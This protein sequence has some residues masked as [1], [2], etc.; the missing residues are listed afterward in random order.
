MIVNKDSFFTPNIPNR[1]EVSAE[2]KAQDG[3]NETSKSRICKQ[4][5]NSGEIPLGIAPN[6][7]NPYSNFQY[8]KLPNPRVNVLQIQCSR[9]YLEAEK[10]Q[11]PTFT[12]NQKIGKYIVKRIGNLSQY[13]P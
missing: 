1:V 13:V 8:N 2:F 6:E 10:N 7:C 4:T 9:T 5:D 12:R 11:I 3:K